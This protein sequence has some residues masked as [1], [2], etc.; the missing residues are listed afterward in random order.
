MIK[1][2]I[3]GSQG[4]TGLRLKDRPMER[5]DLELLTLS[6]EERKSLHARAQKVADAEVAFLFLPHPATCVLV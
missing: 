1:V 3:D 5:N 2:F 6:V 4:T